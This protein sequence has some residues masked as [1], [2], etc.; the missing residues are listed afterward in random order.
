MGACDPST[1]RLV[2]PKKQMHKNRNTIEWTMKN[3]I[4]ELLD[5]F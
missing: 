1:T 3:F 4:I 5:F 2:Q